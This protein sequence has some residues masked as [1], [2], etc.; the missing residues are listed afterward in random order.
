MERVSVRHGA[1]IRLSGELRNEQL[2]ALR[3]EIEGGGPHVTLDLNELNLV[4]IEAVRFLNTCGA[5]GVK[6]VNRSPYIRE[7]MY[8]ER[9]QKND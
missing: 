5:Q 9:N 4:D 2:D 3:S 8:Q 7:W 6:I 1:R